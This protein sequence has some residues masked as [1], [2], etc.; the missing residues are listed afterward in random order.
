MNGKKVFSIL[1]SCAALCAAPVFGGGG[2]Q[3]PASS[4]GGPTPLRIGIGLQP[5]Q[6]A[7]DWNQRLGTLVREKT[8]TVIT[9]EYWPNQ[10]ISE[11]RNV[12]LASGDVPDLISVTQDQA[13]L[14]GMEGVFAPWD[15]LL[16]NAPDLMKYMTTENSS[17]LINPADG[18]KYS[19]P[20]YYSLNTI[21]EWT[22]TYRKDILD[23]MGEQEP[24]TMEGWYQLFKKVKARYP[25]MVILSERNR[26][27]D[28]FTHAAFDMGRIDGYYGIIGSDFDKHQ[29]VYLP[30]TNEWRDMLQ[31]Y[32]RLY[33]EGLLDP[34]YLTIQYNDWWEGKIGSG[35]AFACWTMNMSRADSAN[36]LAQTA[37]INTE[38]KV[39]T[40]VKNYKSGERIQYKTG[41]PWQ[42]EG[43]ALNAKSSP[44]VKE[45][46]IRFIN[47]FFTDEYIKFANYG[48][49]GRTYVMRG[50][51]YSRT[52]SEVDLWTYTGGNGFFDFPTMTPIIYPYDTNPP[53][54]AT[55]DHYQKNLQYIRIIPSI[56]RTGNNTERWVSITTDIN[57]AM[58]TAMDEFITGKRPFSQ[59]DAYVQQI[60]DMSGD[61]AVAIVQGWYD[62]YWKS[63]GK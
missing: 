59:W 14:Y 45:A 63:V 47:F 10:A 16:R 34:E 32:N 61:E 18:K 39:A 31:Y 35:R 33:T 44:A 11:R 6:T 21:T 60:K 29:I 24:D 7:P 9:G 30:I 28:M 46:A 50:N 58:T 57:T 62:N 22:F 42:T 1:V 15:D 40:T 12:A 25:D 51:D 41:N 49:E 19:I 17:T 38:W 2:Q 3:A 43:F 56:S 54:P 37:G 36:Q 26:G 4:A 13:N 20:K 48:D 8:N 53:M 52:V 27:V 55:L 23:A 5:T